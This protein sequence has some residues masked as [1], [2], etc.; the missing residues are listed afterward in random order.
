MFL[1]FKAK[2]AYLKEKCAFP[3]NFTETMLKL[4]LNLEKFP[5]TI[6]LKCS[7]MFLK[8]KRVEFKDILFILYSV[9]GSW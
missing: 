5:K 6:F 3:L 2:P 7:S 4:F 1:S 9:I 8:R